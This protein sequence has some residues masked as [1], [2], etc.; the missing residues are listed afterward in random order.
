MLLSRQTQSQQHD[1][2]RD[3]TVSKWLESLLSAR[4]GACFSRKGASNQH[5]QNCAS[6]RP[7]EIRVLDSA[8][9]IQRVI[10]FSETDR[11]L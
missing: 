4:R 10:S 2:D 1:G 6:F 7:G 11:K 8:G 9:N 3:Q 5:A